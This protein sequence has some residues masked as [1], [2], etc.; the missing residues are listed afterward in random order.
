MSPNPSLDLTTDTN[1]DQVSLT[2]IKPEDKNEAFLSNSDDSIN[3]YE[4]DSADDSSLPMS[5]FTVKPRTDEGTVNGRIINGGGKRKYRKS[6]AVKVE[7]SNEGNEM[8]IKVES[9]E[10]GRNDK[11]ALDFASKLIKDSDIEKKL[12]LPDFGEKLIDEQMNSRDDNGNEVKK[13]RIGWMEEELQL[14]LKA[15]DLAKRKHEYAL[16]LLRSSRA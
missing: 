14:R 7:G 9:D 6:K 2:N 3:S 4:S 15:I 12:A 10:I 5:D 11:T 13:A 8:E 1:P 16:A